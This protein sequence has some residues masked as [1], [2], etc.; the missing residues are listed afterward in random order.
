MAF[1]FLSTQQLIIVGLGLSVTTRI[2]NRGG[3]RVCKMLSRSCTPCT[4]H[5][6][7]H[8]RFIYAHNFGHLTLQFEFWNGILQ[9]QHSFL[10]YYMLLI[11]AMIK[12][13]IIMPYYH[14][15]AGS[16]EQTHQVPYGRLAG[17]AYRKDQVFWRH[18]PFPATE[19]HGRFCNSN[20]GEGDG[21]DCGDHH[22]QDGV[23]D[24]N[25]GQDQ[26]VQHH[27]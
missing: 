10:L 17:G 14:V 1:T 24:S 23:A 21:Q 11:Y 26:A 9:I 15:Q 22:D 20:S 8:M 25:G 13:M 19:N 2:Y 12:L 6:C 5:A 18:N 7:T 27:L 3:E 4:M 16:R